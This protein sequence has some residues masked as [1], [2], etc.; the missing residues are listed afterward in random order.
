MF[1][2]SV[3]SPATFLNAFE[4]DA[5][6]TASA[7]ASSSPPLVFAGALP[8]AERAALMCRF[9]ERLPQWAAKLVPKRCVLRIIL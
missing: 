5:A 9:D 3:Q 6:N 8:L 4:P 7:N 2:S 1:L